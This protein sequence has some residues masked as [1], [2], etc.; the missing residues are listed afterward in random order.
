MEDRVYFPELPS[1]NNKEKFFNLKIFLYL[2]ILIIAAFSIAAFSYFLGKQSSGNN[3]AANN[4]QENNAVESTV[5]LIKTP[6]PLITLD[7]KKL[8][9][10]P[11]VKVKII[12][13]DA[14][15]DGFITSANDGNSVLEIR[16]GKNIDKVA[17]GFISFDL[18]DITP[19]AKIVKASL[20]L[21]QTL[22]VG[23]PFTEGGTIKIDHLTYGDSLDLNDYGLS[24]L[25]SNFAALPSNSKKDWKEAD[26]TS[27]VNDD[28]ANARSR[29]QF[30]IHFQN[31]RS[32]GNE[33][34][35]YAY[36]ESAD[37][38]MGS[39]NIPQLVI[40]YY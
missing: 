7:P 26:V 35:D 40:S 25:V 19:G 38:S 2:L 33:K 15:L 27:A 9:P 31:E 1:N 14:K 13:A 30:R 3:D 11:D 21:Y 22:T 8:S 17:R 5:S 24:A 12:E 39:S 20:K 32:G 23:S 4:T 36:F 28:F 29:S 37:N 16:V 6:T 34:G 10:T 18:K